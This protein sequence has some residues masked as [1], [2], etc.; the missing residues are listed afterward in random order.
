MRALSAKR[1]GRD[2]VGGDPSHTISLGPLSPHT[3]WIKVFFYR[4][5]VSLS[6]WNYDIQ[7]VLRF[8][9]ASIRLV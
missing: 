8:T 5:K 9:G 3:C 7:C 1:L 6:L 2:K 4:W